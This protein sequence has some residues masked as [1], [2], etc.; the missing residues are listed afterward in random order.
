MSDE[1][2]ARAYVAAFNA[3]V[4]TGDW[5][6]FTDALHPDAVMTFTGPPVGPF[7]GREAIARAYAADPPDDTIEPV[8]FGPD[9]VVRFRWSRGGAG[10]VV[11]GWAGGRVAR[12]AIRF[13]DDPA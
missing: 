9:G 2:A 6:T 5:Q 13:H 10:T 11:L 7:H 3:A 8:E 1:E 12:V 4:T